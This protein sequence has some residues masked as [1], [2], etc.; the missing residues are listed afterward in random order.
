MNKIFY[1][2]ATLILISE[3][4]SSNGIAA[5]PPL[6]ELAKQES[7]GQ[8]EVVKE[9]VDDMKLRVLE[10]KTQSLIFK[11][12]LKSEGFESNLPTVAI[13]HTNEMSSR[14][15]VDSVTY[16]LDN[17]RVYTYKKNNRQKSGLPKEVVI[18]KGLLPPGNHD[19]SVEI[20]YR[21]N[22][23]GVFSYV[24]DYKITSKS[25]K[26][27]KVDKGQN[28]DV[29]VVAYEKGWALTD[30]KDRPDL[31]INFHSASSPKDLR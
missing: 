25:T 16:L 24:N 26:T 10:K 22:D 7:K 20:I 31:K 14:Y 12:M 21:G 5:S 28:L 8:P 4:F 11:K 6:T 2:L 17:D 15:L 9:N 23:V 30:F 18:F 13:N 29:Q 27:F 1:L 19:L 3:G